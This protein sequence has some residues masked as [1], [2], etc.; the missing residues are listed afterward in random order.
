[1]TRDASVEIRD[2]RIAASIGT[3]GAHDVVPDD[4]LLDLTL[5]ISPDLA[6]V[7]ADDM[8]LVFDY[9]PLVEQID[10]IAQ[11]QHY[12]TQEFLMTRIVRACAAYPQ[13]TGVDISLRKRPIRRG[14]GS[15]GVR[16]VL[17]AQDLAALRGP[18]A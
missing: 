6:Q 11:S 17:A 9:D 2:F 1:M 7:A 5:R 14:S 18:A 13:I 4:H 10:Q 12:A 8:A 16:L 15:L 3:Y